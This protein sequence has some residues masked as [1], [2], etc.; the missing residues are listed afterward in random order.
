[1]RRRA[2]YQRKLKIPVIDL[3]KEIAQGRRIRAE[4]EQ[5]KARAYKQTL[6]E[7]RQRESIRNPRGFKA[8]MESQE[9]RR[10]RE[11]S[12]GSRRRYY[13]RPPR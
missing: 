10:R 3:K 5:G 7:E 6:A 1:M 13:G 11:E 8:A 12:L 2:R 9:F 4:R